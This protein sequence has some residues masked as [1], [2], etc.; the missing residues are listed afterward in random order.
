MK[1]QKVWP[2]P[3]RVHFL[4]GKQDVGSA[5][6]CPVLPLDVLMAVIDKKYI[7]QITR[8]VSQLTVG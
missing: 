3:G 5:N 1:K 4:L 7:M 6:L 2:L 8:C